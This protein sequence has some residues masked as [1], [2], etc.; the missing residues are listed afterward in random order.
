[1]L[2]S[3]DVKN[4]ALIKSLSV[5][6]SQGL[7]ILSG[8][9][10]AGKSILIDSLGLALGE[11]A[12]RGLIRTG[13]DKAFVQAL[14]DVSQ[15]EAAMAFIRENELDCED[16]SCAVSREITSSG[17]SVCRICGQIVPLNMLKAFTSL[18]VDI[19]GQHEH[20][21]LMNDDYHLR[22]IDSFG[23]KDIAH[24]QKNVADAY[25]DYAHLR[26]KLRDFAGSPQE[27]A[28]KIDMLAYQIDEI[29]V[30]KLKVDEEDELIKRRDF[31][32]NAQQIAAAVIEA[33]EK[34]SGAV[35]GDLKT[36]A[37][38]MASVGRFDEKYAEIAEKLDECYYTLEDI[39]FDVSSMAD[40]LDYDEREV[41]AVEERLEAI[42]MLKRKYGKSIFKILEY[43]E[44]AQ[45]ELDRLVN[46]EATLNKMTVAIETAKKRLEE[47][48]AAL[49]NKRKSVA[50]D[51]CKR[52]VEHLKDL[53]MSKI[54]LEAEFE[55]AEI[56]AN[57]WDA[58]RFM[59]AAN[60][61]EPLKPLSKTASGGELSRI[62]LALK[63]VS[64]QSDSI[65]TMIFDEI[66]TGIS[67]RAAVCVAAK[68]RS[69]ARNKQVLCVTHLASI[70]A[71]GD[72]HFLIEKA[73]TDDSTVTH[74]KLLEGERRV[75]EIARLSGGGET[76][77]A[78]LHA[79]EMMAQAAG[80]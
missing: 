41:D 59:L 55:K 17:R 8:E 56:S 54:K 23:A 5:E 68:M 80:D 12:D 74:L 9:T 57:G 73:S 20:Q 14:F 10:G 69:I 58:V 61:G 3:L 79:R 2:I 35:M 21:S 42:S 46:S 32:R 66:D 13:S 72:A 78:L 47:E 48:C 76:A 71:A 4:V 52:V 33:R 49:S 51:F 18:I 30:A 77:A 16:G 11:R 50:N 53:S 1:M 7:I 40:D 26:K 25:A 38:G 34:L 31:F 29:K 19:H 28:Q 67:G 65:G 22:C 36:A 60:P 15:N 27:M 44:N 70:A 6:L 63:S 62:M 75:A 43:L 45:S 24:L 37:R 39:S 64:A